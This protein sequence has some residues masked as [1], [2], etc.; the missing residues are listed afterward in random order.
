MKYLKSTYGKETRIKILAWNRG[1]YFV[2]VDGMAMTCRKN[3]ELKTG[4]GRLFITQ[5]WGARLMQTCLEHNL[6]VGVFPL[7]PD[8]TMS[9]R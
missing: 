5:P 6:S 4:G 7:L 9:N 8:Q 3:Q 1:E 2:S